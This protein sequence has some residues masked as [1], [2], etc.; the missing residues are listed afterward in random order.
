MKTQLRKKYSSDLTDRQWKI[1]EPLIPHAR[2]NEKIGGAPER[3]PKQ[4]IVNGILYVKT[5]GCKW[6][7]LPHDLPPHGAVYHYF[8]TWSKDGT[9]AEINC[10]LRERTRRRE[11]KNSQPTV[12]II[13]ARSVKNGEIPDVSGYDAGK[14][15]KGIKQHIAVD[16]LG[17]LITVVV[18][19]ADIQDRDGA[20]LVLKKLKKIRTRL[21]KIFVDQ[22]YRGTLIAWTFRICHWTLE[23]VKRTGKGFVVLPKRWIVERTFSWLCK[24]RR[25]VINYEQTI[26]NAEAMVYVC[27]IHIMTK[28][29]DKVG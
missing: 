26:R 21:K 14:K 27:M 22:G 6:K 25:L 18:H 16:T 11:K 19:A 17:L 12:A 4:E 1:L 8:N 13:D 3:Y 5:N 15:V 9:W 10:L 7:D 24:S 29:L 20:K 28:R 23:V 2:S